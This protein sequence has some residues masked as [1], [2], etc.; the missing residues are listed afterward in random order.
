MS[1]QNE[2]PNPPREESAATPQE[3]N[4]GQ[5]DI[6]MQERKVRAQLKKGRHIWLVIHSTP[7]DSSAVMIS[8]NGYAYRIRRDEPACVPEAVVEILK[9]AKYRKATLIRDPNGQRRTEFR[10]VYRYSFS[11]SDTKPET[12][13]NEA[14]AARG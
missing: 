8:V 13:E 12:P 1:R 14:Y 9:L 5:N 10:T 11:V 6:V 7:N 3:K 4:S 2:M